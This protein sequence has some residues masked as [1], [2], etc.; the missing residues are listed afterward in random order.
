M[1]AQRK[2]IEVG[3]SRVKLVKGRA[4]EVTAPP[5]HRHLHF[6]RRP[7]PLHIKP[8]K[9]PGISGTDIVIFF[10]TTLSIAAVYCRRF[11]ISRLKYNF[12]ASS[13]PL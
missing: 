3:N 6:D 2:P 13:K 4:F 10:S 8:N 5:F 1:N 7:M 9:A 11:S 12:A